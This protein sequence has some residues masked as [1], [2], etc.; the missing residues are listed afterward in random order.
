VDVA[1]IDLARETAQ[2]RAAVDAP[3]GVLTSGRYIL[4]EDGRAFEAEFAAWNGSSH[5]V[6]CASGTDA[7]ELALRALGVGHGD[8]VVMQ[9][10]TCIPTVAA[11]ER[12][13]AVPVLCDVQPTATLDPESLARVLTENPP[14]APVWAVLRHGRHHRSRRGNPGGRGLRAGRRRRR[15]RAARRP[16]G[17]LGTFSFYPTK[18]L[19]A[20]G[21]GG[22]VTANEAELAERM[23]V[24]RT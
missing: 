16:M 3:L 1:F 15:P 24:L 12:A 13:G 4:G 21:D 14:G 23:R 8:E 5:V 2:L 10:N 17:T 7:F 11:I 6:G 9:A 19:G 18:N 20:L 22:A